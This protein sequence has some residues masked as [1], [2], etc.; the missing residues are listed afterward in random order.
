M[1]TKKIDPLDFR[2]LSDK[3]I[4]AIRAVWAGEAQPHEQKLALN[5]IIT[6]FCKYPKSVPFSPGEPDETAFLAGRF[7]VGQSVAEIIE[8][9]MDQL[10]EVEPSEHEQRD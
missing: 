1:P 10:I 5:T 4:Y 6:V 8:K 9:P 7:F 3:E 2:K